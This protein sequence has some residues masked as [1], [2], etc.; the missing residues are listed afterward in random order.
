MAS[1]ASDNSY[2]AHDLRDHVYDR[3]KGDRMTDLV[4]ITGAD[5]RL[6]GNLFMLLEGTRQ[7]EPGLSLKICDFG[8][9]DPAKAFL[10][11]LGLLLPKPAFLKDYDH[12]WYAKA[13]M[14]DYVE[15]AHPDAGGFVWIDADIIPIKPFQREIG[16]IALD[17]M[18]TRSRWA[19]CPD[20]TGGSI[21]DF[22]EEWIAR[23]SDMSPFQTQ[24][25]A[26][27]VSGEQAYL[28]TGFLI[29]TEG[30]A[31]DQWRR[32]TLQQ[33]I[34]LLFEQ[35]SFNTLAH[36]KPKYTHLL[37]T[38]VWNAHG[39]MLDHV[40]IADTDPTIFV[41]ATSSG[42]R[43]ADGPISLSVEG[44]RLDLNLKLL[45]KPD[46]RDRQLQLLSSF[47]ERHGADLDA[48]GLLSDVA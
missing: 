34:W 48:A 7:T 15:A 20:V 31:A 13:A 8:F 23:G 27:R 45:L 3:V 4:F 26:H 14:G 2:R 46:L 28:N 19:L 41:H 5:D 35:N 47:L 12:P 36:A 24:L 44:K 42:D 1:Q 6:L 38:Q 25:A 9:S 33:S 21:N 10:D 39:E 37:D 32:L 22:I 18:K 43:H 17:M 11:G 40:K 29:C 30:S 16:H